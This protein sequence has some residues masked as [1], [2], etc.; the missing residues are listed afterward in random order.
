[1]QVYN[2]VIRYKC[3]NC[4]AEVDITPAAS[5]GVLTMVGVL[6]FSFWGW[7]TFGR[8]GE[9]SITSLSL[10]AAAVIIFS[11][12]AFA[13]LAKHFRNPLVKAGARN[14]PP[15][16]A[17]GDHIAK[18]PILWVERLGYFAGLLVPVVVILGVLGVAALIGYIN[19]TYFSN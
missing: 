3:D 10:F 11:L 2:S 13:P 16:D 14:C 17:G 6:A 8:G 4:S 5:I 1:M 19:F 18:R 12:I 9:V 7:I 15:L